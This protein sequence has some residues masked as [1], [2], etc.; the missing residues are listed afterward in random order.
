MRAPVLVCDFDGTWSV[1]DVGNELCERYGAPDWR[2][3]LER[4]AR[5][6]LSPHE[7]AFAMWSTVTAEVHELVA[8]AREVGILRR[9]HERLLA[10]ANAGK[11]TLVLASGGYE[12]YIAPLLGESR[13]SFRDLYCHELGYDAEGVF[14]PTLRHGELACATCALCKGELVRCLVRDGERVA[15]AGDGYTDL[16]VIETGVPI[17]AVA[18]SVLE[19][20]CRERGVKHVSFES[21]SEVVAVL[22]TL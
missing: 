15:F 19:R 3:H 13:A 2:A 12:L 10:E 14:R 20:A 17:F 16:C 5:G 7:A 22:P 18:G 6:E 11:V 9:D 1:A 8:H 21:W 4:W